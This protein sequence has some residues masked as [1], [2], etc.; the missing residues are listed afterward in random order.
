M[1]AK[2]CPLVPLI[3][4]AIVCPLALFGVLFE[5]S[6][7]YVHI[8]CLALLVLG[9]PWLLSLLIMMAVSRARGQADWL[10]KQLM[11]LAWT[12]QLAFYLLLSIQIGDLLAER[13]LQALRSYLEKEAKAARDDQQ[14]FADGFAPLSGYRSLCAKYAVEW[15]QDGAQGTFRYRDPRAAVTRLELIR[16]G[17]QWAQVN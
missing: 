4:S 6:Y 17:N 11:T 13:E 9:V 7:F 1:N 12:A 16:A 10:S 3:V 5:A 14:P 2:N 8:V 15:R